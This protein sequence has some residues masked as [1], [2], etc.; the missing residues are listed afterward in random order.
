MTT[1]L[2]LALSGPCH[3]IAAGQ[4]SDWLTR[5]DAYAQAQAWGLLGITAKVYAW[6]PRNDYRI[7]S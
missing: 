4:V 2:A 3:V 1:L 6:P 7:W 5:K